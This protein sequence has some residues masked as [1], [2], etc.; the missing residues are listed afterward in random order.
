MLLEEIPIF[1]KDAC[2]LLQAFLSRMPSP[3][4]LIAHNGMKFDFPLLKAELAS[5]N[6]VIVF[7]QSCLLR[8]TF[9]IISLEELTMWWQWHQESNRHLLRWSTVMVV[10]CWMQS[11]SPLHCKSS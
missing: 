6:E 7:I 1:D 8:E 5:R 9:C 10:L 3:M 4:C 11:P 2:G